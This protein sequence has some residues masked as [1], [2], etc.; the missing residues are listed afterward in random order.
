MV[1]GGADDYTAAEPCVELG[2][3]IKANGGNIEV[4]VKKGW[5][6]GFTANY[7]EEWEKKEWYLLIVEVFSLMMMEQRVQVIPIINGLNHGGLINV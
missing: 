4:T 5:H 1:L 3:K 7:E 6:H 2:K